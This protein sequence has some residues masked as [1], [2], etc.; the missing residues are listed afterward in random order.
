MPDDRSLLY[1]RAYL[2]R[3]RREAWEAGRD[4]AASLVERSSTWPEIAAAHA[5]WLGDL[6]QSHGRAIRALTPPEEPPHDGE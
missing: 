2:A 1:T 3:A 4:A 5:A 6:G